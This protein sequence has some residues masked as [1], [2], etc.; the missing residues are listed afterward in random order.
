MSTAT[1]PQKAE[2]TLWV[3]GPEDL[4]DYMQ[5]FYPNHPQM[6]EEEIANDKMIQ[7]LR[8]FPVG[9]DEEIAEM[10]E[11]IRDAWRTT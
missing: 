2:K 6:T 3:L 8:N 4:D 10:E 1:M 9:T 11:A 7:L 5:R